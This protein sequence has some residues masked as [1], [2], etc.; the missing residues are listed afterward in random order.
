MKALRKDEAPFHC[1]GIS[2]GQTSFDPKA[3]CFRRTVTAAGPMW[4]YYACRAAE[5]GGEDEA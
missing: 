3:N 2:L 4:M 5:S 1:T